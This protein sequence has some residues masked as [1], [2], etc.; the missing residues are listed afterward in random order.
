[1]KPDAEPRICR[2]TF[3]SFY[4]RNSPRFHL[5]RKDWGS[6]TT[7]TK[8]LNVGYVALGGKVEIKRSQLTSASAAAKPTPPPQP[9]REIEIY[10]RC[11]SL[12]LYW[13]QASRYS[14]SPS[15]RAG[16]NSGTAS[17]RCKCPF[18]LHNCE[19][20][21]SSK[22]PDSRTA[23]R[24]IYDISRLY[25]DSSFSVDVSHRRYVAYPTHERFIEL[26]HRWI[27]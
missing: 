17:T 10:R 13:K 22:F 4:Q 15:C 25:S 7:V 6:N 12:P 16:Y 5:P 20:V 23:V 8:S 9:R 21:T 18:S 1:M 2:V 3:F 11:G 19:D 26:T 24:V 14:K 27:I